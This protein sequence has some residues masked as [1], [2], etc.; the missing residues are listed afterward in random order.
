MRPPMLDPTAGQRA[1]AL[2]ADPQ[3]SQPNSDPTDPRWGRPS[4]ERGAPA[5]V[6]PRIFDP[7]DPECGEPR[8]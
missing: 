4:N 7:T 1:H 8:A 3:G 6:V 2:H 5:G